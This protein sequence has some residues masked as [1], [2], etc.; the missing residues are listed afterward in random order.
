MQKVV[1][2]ILTADKKELMRQ[3]EALKGHTKWMHIDIMDGRFVPNVSMSISELGEAHQFFS[4]EIHLMVQDPEKYL[5]DCSAAG[6]KRVIFH[7]EGTK[8]PGHVFSL[9]KKYSFQIGIALNPETKAEQLT[10]FTGNLDSILLMSIVPGAQGNEFIPSVTK[11]VQQIR[12]RNPDIVIGMD[13]GITKENIRQV[14]LAGVDYTS[15]GSSIWKTEDPIVALSKF[16]EMV[17]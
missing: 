6:A 9:A 17:S 13:G 4:L 5:E 15:V 12:A 11:K 1:P 7:L 3:L 2:A 10:S 8:D 16:E 14:F